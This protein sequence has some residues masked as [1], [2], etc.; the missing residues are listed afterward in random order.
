M[1]YG[2]NGSR[3]K[4]VNHNF[5]FTNETR[6]V[7]VVRCGT[8]FEILEKRKLGMTQNE[9]EIIRKIISLTF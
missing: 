7:R 3:T 8:I 5:R 6:S 1:A 2:I 9:K 4:L